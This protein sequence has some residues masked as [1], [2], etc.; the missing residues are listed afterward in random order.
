MLEIPG[1]CKFTELCTDSCQIIT[2]SVCNTCLDAIRKL[3][4]FR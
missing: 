4:N 3:I 2:S 1:G